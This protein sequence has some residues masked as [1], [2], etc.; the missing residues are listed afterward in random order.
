M[1]TDWLNTQAKKLNDILDNVQEARET[2]ERDGGAAGDVV[3][4]PMRRR[5]DVMPA[6]DPNDDAFTGLTI[7][8]SDAELEALC[9]FE[10]IEW[11]IADDPLL[12]FWLGKDCK[13]VPYEA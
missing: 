5:F 12:T 8:L 2:V 9:E 4:D 3:F 7:W 13:G 11:L 1:I 6:P 10:Y